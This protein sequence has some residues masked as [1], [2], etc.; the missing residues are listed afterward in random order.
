MIF[1]ALALKLKREAQGDFRGRHFK[2]HCGSVGVDESYI[3]VRG[4]RRG[5]QA[6]SPAATLA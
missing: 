5:R 2:P 4:Q 1:H 3:R 6:R